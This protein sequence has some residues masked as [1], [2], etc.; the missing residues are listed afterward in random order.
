[1]VQNLKNKKQKKAFFG[2]ISSELA[3]HCSMHLL[4]NGWEVS[5]TYRIKSELTNKL[6]NNGANLYAFDFKKPE[7]LYSLLKNKDFANDWDFL[8]VSPSMLGDTGKFSDIKWK[9][10]MDTFNLNF[11]S[12]IHFIH[13]ILPRRN[14]NGTPF[15]WLWSGPGTNNAPKEQSAVIIAKVAQI[16]FVEILNEEYSDLTPVV[17]GPGWVNTKTHNE[18]LS[19]GPSA[20]YK[21]FQTKERI[22]SGNFTSIDTIIQFLDWILSQSKD[23]IGGRNFSIRSDIWQKDKILTDYLKGDNNAFKLRRYMNDWRPNQF[24]NTDFEPKDV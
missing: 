23:A 20:G 16:K 11:S 13:E 15:L 12:Q 8:M 18:V 4:Q 14:K 19:M 2:S 7:G 5:G 1:M 21:Y 22:A 9:S 24:N 3:F 10:W 6:I 17:I